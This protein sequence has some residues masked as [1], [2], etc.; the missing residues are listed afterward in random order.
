MLS[1]NRC[2]VQ[3]LLALAL[4]CCAGVGH[5]Q[6]RLT[7]D[8]AVAL[9]WSQAHVQDEFAASIAAA[10][11]DVLSARTWANPT[12]SVER[13]ELRDRASQPG[14]ETSVLLTQPFELGGRRGA[15]I[16]AA[17]AGVAAAQADD[18]YERVRLRGDVLRDYYAAVATERRMQAQDKIAGGLASLANIAGKR[19]REG[20]LSGYESRRIAQASAQAHARRTQ[21][22]AEGL[23]ARTRLA[24]WIGDAA[25]TAELDAAITLPAIADGAD[26]R[27]AELDALD[28]RRA[29][30]QAEATAARRLSLPVTLGVGTKRI[31]EG[32]ASDDALLLEVG[33]PLPLFDRNQ[34]ERARADAELQRANA[35]YQ[36]ALVRTRARRA[37]A[38]QEARQLVES[39]RAMQADLV[40]EAAR[41]TAIA[42]SSF[43]EG[44]L[45]LVGLLDA[46]EAEAAVVE[47]SLEQQGRALDALL[48]LERLS[49]ATLDSPHVNPRR[50]TP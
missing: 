46:F 34:G 20:D 22:A 19:Q 1:S 18:A 9:A 10:R 33:V 48:E 12:L 23:A 31:R 13:E 2:G 32:G 49:P 44:E 8:E 7:A 27:S 40:P 45:D 4:L 6:Q 42:R 3:R 24:G 29:Q 41:L 16:R 5:A 14:S 17:Q 37:A 21:A 15:R 35:Q 25:M 28:A 30:A 39:A 36:R 50:R 43:A 38:L 26:T 47:Q 11:G